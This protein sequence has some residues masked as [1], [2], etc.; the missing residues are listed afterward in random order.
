MNLRKKLKKWGNSLVVV[1]TKE[2][3]DVYSLKEGDN[4]D[5]S[6]MFKQNIHNPKKRS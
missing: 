3:D 4:I 6:D 1:F 2:D 5:I